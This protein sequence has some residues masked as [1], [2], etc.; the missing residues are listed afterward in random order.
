MSREAPAKLRV[1]RRTACVCV[2]EG[3]P[4]HMD[5]ALQLSHITRTPTLFP[6]VQAGDKAFKDELGKLVDVSVWETARQAVSKEQA[7]LCVWGRGA[8]VILRPIF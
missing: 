8:S 5:S 2:V 6:T 7:S 4:C 1:Q 3:V